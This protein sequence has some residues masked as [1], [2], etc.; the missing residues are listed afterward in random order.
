[1]NWD[2]TDVKHEKE[3]VKETFPLIKVSSFCFSCRFQIV[4]S[5]KGLNYR[6]A[7]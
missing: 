1:M 4:S 6:V 2:A 3:D 5:H 7:R